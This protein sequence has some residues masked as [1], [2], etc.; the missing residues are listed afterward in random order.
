MILEIKESIKRPE[1]TRPWRRWW[2]QA[3]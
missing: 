1:F 2:G 3:L